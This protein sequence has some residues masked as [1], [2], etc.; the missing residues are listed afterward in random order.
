MPARFRAK[1]EGA[2]GWVLRRALV[3]LSWRDS[4]VANPLVIFSDLD[5]TFLDAQTYSY[6]PVRPIL[7]RL[8][9]Q[10]IPLVICS[11][12]TRAEIEVWIKTLGLDA[13]F[14]IENGSA[15]VFPPSWP[16]IL[17]SRLRL[18]G[19]KRIL[20]LGL[21]R[22]TVCDALEELSK[23]AGI[24]VRG[25]S[26]MPVHEIAERTGLSLDEAQRAMK[27]EYSEPFVVEGASS[28]AMKRFGELVRRRG[29]SYTHGGRF[30]HLMGATDKGKAVRILTEV[31]RRRWDDIRTVAL[32]DSLND[33]PMLQAA[34]IPVLVNRPNGSY[35]DSPRD[36]RFYRAPGVGPEG[37]AE[38]VGRL[39]AHKTLT[40][41]LE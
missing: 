6:E 29:M 3:W 27:R 7:T 18:A 2:R 40:D 19:D 21:P 10:G 39:L 33:I 16:V 34:D 5:G 31:M 17:N 12:K 30:H 9:E 1:G 4:A 14:I 22:Q 37:W 28:E 38:A 20:E 11:S 41:K 15:I 35:A 24:R 25:F 13:P 26:V 23:K 36:L 32:G 8:K